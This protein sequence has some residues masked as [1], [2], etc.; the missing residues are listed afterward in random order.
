MGHV[1]LLSKKEQERKNKGLSDSLPLLCED[2]R[3]ELEAE[4]IVI[5][6]PF[7]RG[8]IFT[9]S[10]H[11]ISRVF[12]DHKAFLKYSN[13]RKSYVNGT[14]FYGKKGILTEPGS[15]VWY[16]KRRMM[17]PA[18]QKKYLRSLMRDMTSKANKFCH[19]LVQKKGQKLINI[20]TIMNRVTLEIVCKCGFSLNDDFILLERSALN[21]AIKTLLE[22][23]SLSGNR[24][25]KFPWKFREEKARLKEASALMRGTLRALL[26]E[27]VDKNTKEPDQ[28]SN[29]I[30]DHIIRGRLLIYQHRY[31]VLVIKIE[32]YP[33][34]QIV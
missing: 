28:V 14:R 32:Q 8:L 30:L 27:R 2:L 21:D 17:D 25:F 7:A 13:T 19:F 20:F 1:P 18:F 16:H 5:F 26:E 29:D 6:F 12:I 23:V 24:S 31:I 9:V 4:T 33:N 22:V 10:N 15:E 11:I 34:E 3:R